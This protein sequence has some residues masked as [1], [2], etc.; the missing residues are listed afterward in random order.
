MLETYLLRYYNKLDDLFSPG[1]VLV[2]YGPRQVGKT[3][4]LHHYLAQG[5]HRYKL[6][7][8]DNLQV[9]TLLEGA[10]FETIADY[11][12]GYDLIVIDEAQ[13]IPRIG[14]VLKI[15]V[16]QHPHLRVIATG[17][18]SFEL[19]GQVGE[20]LAGRKKTLTLYPFSQLELS[21][22]HNP[23]E[24]KQHLADWLIYGSYPQVVAAT[25]KA[26]KRSRVVEIT[27]SYLLKDILAF[28]KIKNP[29]VLLD[30]L[31]L[32]AFQIGNE[33]SLTELAQKLMI[34][35]K[36]VARYIDLLE[37]TFV[38]Y[39]LRGFSR[40]LRNEVVKKSK[41]YFYDVGIRNALIANFNAF[42]LRDDVGCLWENFL[43]MERLKK[44]AYHDVS[45]NYYFWRTWDQKEIDLIEEREGKLWGYE[46]KWGKK[47][48]KAPKAWLETYSNASFTVINQKNYQDFVGKGA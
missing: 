41:Y 18:S 26:E 24:L 6:D 2:I 29:K 42:E 14:E 37:K 12:A 8:G 43:F 4:L 1:S 23:L 10:D 9:R 21:H 27:E 38:L 44:Q 13:K 3:T 40:N 16:D 22:Y 28:D 32:L 11:V 17:S 15:M 5:S 19:A 30:L 34:N 39:N 48:V 31:R 36:T 35:S 7:S 20:P 45:V 25:S 46:F 47:T 33:V